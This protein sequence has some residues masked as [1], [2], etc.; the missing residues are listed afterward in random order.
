MAEGYQSIR[1][2]FDR[3]LE[4]SLKEATRQKRKG[5]ATSIQFKIEDNTEIKGSLKRF[6]S[7][8]ATKKDLVSYLAKK[9]HEFLQLNSWNY[10][11]SADGFTVGNIEGHTQNNHEEAD[12]LVVLHAIE[13]SSTP[14][15]GDQ[16]HHV[17][18]I[19]PDTDVFVLLCSHHKTL[20]PKTFMQVNDERI[21]DIQKT[22]EG[23]GC[24]K[25]DALIGLHAFS[26]CDTTGK[27]NKKGKLKWWKNFNASST[28]IINAFVSL[29]NSYELEDSYMTKFEEFVCHVYCKKYKG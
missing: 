17:T 1:V 20:A 15:A 23:I 29:G 28:P 13:A 22:V 12:T 2:A 9:L 7:N 19:S 18:I 27:F 16:E 24:L 14:L 6:L 26:G 5:Q 4:S 11:V 3:Y 21:I 10:A 8:E 25:A